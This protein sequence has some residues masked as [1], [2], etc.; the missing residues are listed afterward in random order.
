MKLYLINLN[1]KKQ[2][3][4]TAESLSKEI[5]KEFKNN[6]NINIK[7]IVEYKYEDETDLKKLN[8]KEI[9]KEKKA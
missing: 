2:E 9:L 4:Y 3:N 5:I 1:V 7:S 6:W 8:I